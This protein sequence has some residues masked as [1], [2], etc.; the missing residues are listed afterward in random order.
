MLGSQ[1]MTKYFT[2]TFITDKYNEAKD[3]KTQLYAKS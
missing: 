2:T 1:N 3:L